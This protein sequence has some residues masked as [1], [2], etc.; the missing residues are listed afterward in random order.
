MARK[1]NGTERRPSR[2]TTPNGPMMAWVTHGQSSPARYITPSGWTSRSQPR[3][4]SQEGSS[5]TSHMLPA[6]N[7]RPGRVV[8]PASHAIGKPMASPSAA[9]AALTHSEL[10]MATAVAPVNAWPR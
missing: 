5:S 7:R 1:V 10:V 4:G 8:R 3:A 6:T 2:N 9:A